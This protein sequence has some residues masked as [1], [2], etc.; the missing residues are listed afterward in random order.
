M[1]FCWLLYILKQYHE[2]LTRNLLPSCLVVFSRLKCRIVQ[3]LYCE[4]NST[5]ER[6]EFLNC[7]SE[8]AAK[9]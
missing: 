5:C 9:Y 6:Q 1:R 2:G 4:R 7:I 3:V 8:L